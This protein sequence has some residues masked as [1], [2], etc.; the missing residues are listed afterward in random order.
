MASKTFINE[1]ATD[2]R[3]K[4]FVR[5]SENPANNAGQ[6]S[7]DLAPGQNENVA[8]GDAINIYLNGISLASLS[9]QGLVGEQEFVIE[10]SSALDNEL[11]MNSIVRISSTVGGF[12]VLCSN[13]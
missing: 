4:L 10:R 6:Q 3:V 7:F 12:Q 1:T 5:A 11:N 8:Y 9:D 2:V 13:S